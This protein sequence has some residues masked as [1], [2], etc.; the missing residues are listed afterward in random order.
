M[1]NLTSIPV[2]NPKRFLA[3][4]DRY[5]HELMED[6]RLDEATKVAACR[7]LLLENKHVNPDWALLQVKAMSR[8]LNRLTQR[9]RQPY[10]AAPPRDDVDEED[11][12]DD[13]AACPV[14]AMVK[15]FLKPAKPPTTIKKTPANQPTDDLEYSTNL[16]SHLPLDD[17][18]LRT[19]PSLALSYW[20]TQ[21]T[22]THPKL[23]STA[24]ID[25]CFRHKSHRLGPGTP[26]HNTP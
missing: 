18:N 3:L 19:H 12:A 10:G 8:K 15:R 9:I 25:G 13:F 24:H 16:W 7:Q 22:R 14:Q 2:S 5:K 23:L 6:Q 4:Q 1:S 21:T 11:P 26:P 17:V 20:T